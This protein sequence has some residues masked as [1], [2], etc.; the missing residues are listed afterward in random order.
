MFAARRELHSFAWRSIWDA[1]WDRAR[2]LTAAGGGRAR[3]HFA[4][5]VSQS[6]P[7]V[8]A[9]LQ[10]RAATLPLVSLTASLGHL[11]PVLRRRRPLPWPCNKA[12]AVPWSGALSSSGR[13]GRIA[14]AVRA[15][16]T[17]GALPGSRSRWPVAGGRGKGA[18]DQMSRTLRVFN[19]G[20][21][22]AVTKKRV[23]D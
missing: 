7:E 14:S 5:G 18:P 12:K 4:L 16:R 19:V 1:P 3:D 6:C 23:V 15:V 2:I 11:P 9:A 22:G 20:S 13:A 17:I 10:A 8:V 21:A